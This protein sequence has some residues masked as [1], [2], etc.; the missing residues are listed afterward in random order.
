M[1]PTLRNRRNY[2]AQEDTSARVVEVDTDEEVEITRTTEQQR[3]RNRAE[4][5]KKNFRKHDEEDDDDDDEFY[6]SLSDVIRI[7]L[8]LIALSVGLSYYVTSGESYIWGF[9]RQRPWWMRSNDIK[10]FLK[11]PV[12][13]T[14]SQLALYDGS[15]PSLPI[16]LALNGTIID[17]SANPGIYGPGGG[18]HFFVGRDATRAFVTGCF[19]E[20]LTNDMTGVE[21]MYIPIEDDNDSHREMT[22]TFTEK[23][24]RR[25]RERREAREK[26]DAQVKHW[27]R[28]YS[29]H[30][31]YFAVGKVIP[32]E[33]GAAD[34]EGEK[35]VLCEGAQKNRP[36]R[37]D[38]NKKL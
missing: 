24:L 27:L 38:L 37:S 11:G 33:T 17:V 18:Y 16:Y 12:N 25:E 1:P 7:I 13:L 36:L 9:E 4:K 6:I 2:T 10:Q 15:D 14:P 35:R 31:K 26:V 3:E 20:D 5:E 23:N 29:G 19:K 28:F 30:E 21:E 22:L 32:E 34:G 8:T